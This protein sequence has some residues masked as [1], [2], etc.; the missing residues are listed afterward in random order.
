[1]YD[2]CFFLKALGNCDEKFEM[3]M[4]GGLINWG[5]AVE[6]VLDYGAFLTREVQNNSGMNISTHA[7]YG[8]IP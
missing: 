8:C 6:K 1:M 3:Y 7:R 2:A 5:E 4:S